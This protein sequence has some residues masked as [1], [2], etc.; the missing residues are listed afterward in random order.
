MKGV[1]RMVAGFRYAAGTNAME[2]PNIFEKKRQ[3]IFH[4]VGKGQTQK[5]FQYCAAKKIQLQRQDYSHLCRVFPIK[6]S[7]KKCHC[8]M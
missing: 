3:F 5:K 4:K 6:M 1:G 2:S 7:R 8:E